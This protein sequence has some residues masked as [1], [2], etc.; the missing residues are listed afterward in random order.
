[1]S[2][3]RTETYRKGIILSTSFNFLS[4]LITFGNNIAIAYFFGTQ[5]KTDVYFYT[6]A[7]IMLLAGFITSINASVL[8]PESMRLRVQEGENEAMAF[9]NFFIVTYFLIGL[10]CVLIL[11]IDPVNSFTFLSSFNEEVLIEYSSILYWMVPLLALIVL[12]TFLTDILASYKYFTIPMIANMLNSSLSLL[13]I[14]IFH[15]ILDVLSII[16]GLFVANAFNLFLLI[17]LL[18]KRLAWNLTLKRIKLSKKI[19]KDILYSK[20]GNFAS[21]VSNYLPYY[22]LSGFSPGIITALNYGRRLA[23]LPNN[24]I[25]AQFSSVAGIKFNDLYASRKFTELNINFRKVLSF[26]FFIIMPISALLFLYNSEV[27]TLLFRRGAF[28]YKSVEN[29]ALFLKYLGLMLPL[30]AVN[31]IVARLFMAGQKIKQSFGYHIFFSIFF[32]ISV[33]GGVKVY[34]VIGYPLALLFVYLINVFTIYLLLKFFFPFIE[35]SKVLIDFF[36]MLVINLFITVVVWYFGECFDFE[37][38]I[39]FITGAT[40]YFILWLFISLLFNLSS[41]LNGFIKSAKNVIIK[42]KS[43]IF[44]SNF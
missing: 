25:V 39:K 15:K 38:I 14:L 8:I 28:D 26:L 1:M 32:I 36:K 42:N 37:G 4:K 17:F 6:L 23:E 18:R 35:Y 31:T 12:V 5:F 34:G 9:T 11:L 13:F 29:T 22:L 30:T 27:V 2:F 44:F 7:T 43:K 21:M 33:W 19:L 20:L 40:F 16:M 10:A 24:L 41:E 3:L